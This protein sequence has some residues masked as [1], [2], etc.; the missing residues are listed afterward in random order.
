MSRKLAT[1][2][3]VAMRD[4]AVRR[5]SAARVRRLRCGLGL[6]REQ[7][8]QLIGCS[9]RALAAWELGETV[10]PLDALTALEA[11][12]ERGKEAA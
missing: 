8:A 2:R 5:A 12:A 1:L 11:L 4:P 7:C 9:V 3:P 10:A 6:T